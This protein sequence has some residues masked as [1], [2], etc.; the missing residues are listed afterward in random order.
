MRPT[1]SDRRL[2]GDDR[3]A[4]DDEGGWRASW[5]TARVT[6]T[7]QHTARYRRA[8]PKKKGCL[9]EGQTSSN[10]QLEQ[11]D[12]A[13]STYLTLLGPGRSRPLKCRC[14]APRADH[15]DCFSSAM[16][17]V[18]N[19]EIELEYPRQTGRGPASSPP[20]A[21]GAFTNQLDFREMLSGS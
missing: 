12:A 14:I 3:T 13:D 1:R 15:S 19:T 20:K 5:P 8:T 16:T 11:G 2:A 7:L 18:T 4:G 6:H 10:C 21:P 9:L 17:W